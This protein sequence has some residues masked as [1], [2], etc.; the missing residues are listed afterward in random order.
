MWEGDVGGW[1]G[2][3]GVWF[4]ESLLLLLCKCSVNLGR[5]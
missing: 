5:C 4:T 2:V 3:K 1:M